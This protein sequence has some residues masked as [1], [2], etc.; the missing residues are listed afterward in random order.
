VGSSLYFI[1]KGLVTGSD[2]P[3]YSE[4]NLVAGIHN[5]PFWEEPT[6]ITFNVKTVGSQYSSCLIFHAGPSPNSNGSGDKSQGNSPK[7][8]YRNVLIDDKNIYL[9]DND[10]SHTD[11]KIPY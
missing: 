10:D 4:P 5:H 1:N 7:V 3:N 2:Y 9:Y 6:I 11:I 8:G